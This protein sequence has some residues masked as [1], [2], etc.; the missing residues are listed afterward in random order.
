M[1]YI[2]SYSNLLLNALLDT[3][4]R[5]RRRTIDSTDIINYE[6]AVVYI[7]K[8]SNINLR[9]NYF[10]D[11]S[12][13]LEEIA[14]YVWIIQKD[15]T[16]TY[17][18]YPWISEEELELKIKNTI[19]SDMSVVYDVTEELLRFKRDRRETFKLKELEKDVNYY[20]FKETSKNIST[21]EKQKENEE[22]KLKK[23]KKNIIRK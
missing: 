14:N 16:E 22:K 4:K 10:N 3:I 15:N 18:L 19:F 7:A 17:T 6:K 2:V 1:E 5:E 9:F 21:L 8:E 20:F 23:I 11:K 13:F 12:K